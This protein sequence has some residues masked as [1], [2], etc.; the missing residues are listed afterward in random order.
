MNHLLPDLIQENTYLSLPERA[1][2][3]YK[4]IEEQVW[5]HTKYYTYVN[6]GY[7]GEKKRIHG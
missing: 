2:E 1:R 7:K 5:L 4:K 6:S 3:K